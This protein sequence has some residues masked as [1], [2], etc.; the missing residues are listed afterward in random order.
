MVVLFDIDKTLLIGS[1]C[2]FHSFKQAFKDLYGENITLDIPNLQGM[3]DKQIIYHV[4]KKN[5]IK[6][7]D[8]N[9]IIDRIVEHY[10]EN[11]KRE[12]IRPL[13][14]TREVLNILEDMRI[15]TGIV[16]GN[17]EEIAW[18]KL[19]KAGFSDYFGFG[20]FGDEGCQRSTLLGLALKRA[21]KIHNKIN[22]KESIMVGDTPR[23]I[24]AGKKV[25]TITVGVATGDFT[26]EDLKKAGADHVLKSLEEKEKFIRI[27]QK[28]MITCEYS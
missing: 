21:G 4:A 16:T 6:I 17:I 22:P 18:I 24:Q 2:H 20:A 15:P 3:T 8:F 28:N 13:R 9:D 14:G 10:K 11:V 23:D 27:I 19:K 12:K 5:S 26:I 1:H 7:S 25:G